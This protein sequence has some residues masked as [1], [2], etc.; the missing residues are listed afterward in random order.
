[1]QF[2]PHVSSIPKDKKEA[3][4]SQMLVLIASNKVGKRPGRV[5]PRAVRK[6][7]QSFPILKNHRAIEKE[8]I[9]DQRARSMVNNQAA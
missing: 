1:N 4:Y 7:T 6:K 3:L 8:K 5:E 2:N 9:L